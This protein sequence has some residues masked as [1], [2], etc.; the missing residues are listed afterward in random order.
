MLDTLTGYIFPK[1]GAIR[2]LTSYHLNYQLNREGCGV[3]SLFCYESAVQLINLILYKIM[4]IFIF[5]LI[6]L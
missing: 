5:Q 3:S 1:R 6:K 4:S 2:L